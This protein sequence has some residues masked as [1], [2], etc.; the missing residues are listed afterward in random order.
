MISRKTIAC[1]IGVTS[2]FCAEAASAQPRWGRERMPAAGACFFEN[3]DFRGRYF[4]VRPGEALRSMPRGMNDK[5]SSIRLLGAA[6]V[7]LFRDDNMRGRSVRFT[8]DVRNLRTVGWNDQVSSI[9]VGGREFGRGGREPGGWRGD[10]DPVW[11]REAIPRE[12]ACFYRDADFRGEYFCVPRGG[13][14]ASLPRGFNDSISS[15]RVF[16]AG[17]QIYQ[18]RDFRGHSTEIRRDVR[19]L[20]GNWRDNVSSIRVY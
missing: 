11:G 15:I 8:T 4:C 10:R 13:T 14:Y 2:L 17:V 16:G 6:E 12:G 19:N 5:I 1:V 18:D 9:E 7:V 20:R 3:A